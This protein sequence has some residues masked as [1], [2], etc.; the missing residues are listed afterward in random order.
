MTVGIHEWSSV[1][2]LMGYDSLLHYYDY[3]SATK[4]ILVN[5]FEHPI[6]ASLVIPK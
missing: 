3:G 6:I 5:M 2:G 4:L 1:F